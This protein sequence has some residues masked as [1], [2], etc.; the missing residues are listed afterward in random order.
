MKTNILSTILASGGVASALAAQSSPLAK[1]AT[2]LCDQY[3]N[4][5]AD[6]YNFNNNVWGKTYA[7]SGSECLYVNSTSTSGVSWTADW[8][9]AGGA[10]QVKSYPYS[11]VVITAPK[12]VSAITSLPSTYNWTYSDT[13]INADVS[14]D[15]FTAAN[16]NHVT[17]SGDYELMIS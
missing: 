5:T 1:R 2:N 9:W 13:N 17:Y 10:T 3:G 7:T 11:G 6:G 14:Y 12:L 15:L 16:K 8:T 4:L